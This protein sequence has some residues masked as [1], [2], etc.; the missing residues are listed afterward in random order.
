[1]CPH[2]V[3]REPAFLFTGATTL[4]QFVHQSESCLRF[5]IILHINDGVSATA[6]LCQKDRSADSYIMQNLSIITKIRDRFNI[7]HIYQLLSL[8]VYTILL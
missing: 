1:M 3:G 8:I 7:R 5:F 2:I 4:C 6:I